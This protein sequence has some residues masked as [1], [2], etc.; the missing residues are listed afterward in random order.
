M[1]EKMAWLPVGE[2]ARILPV[3]RPSG[4][5]GAGRPVKGLAVEDPRLEV[6][7]RRAPYWLPR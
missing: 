2:T 1:S 4:V 5:A 6:V 7:M 3:T